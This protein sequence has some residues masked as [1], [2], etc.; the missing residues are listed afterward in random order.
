MRRAAALPLVLLLTACDGRSA[1][2]VAVDGAVSSAAPAVKSGPFDVTERGVGPLG[3]VTAFS[4]ES[5]RVAYPDTTV[6]RVFLHGAGDPQPILR[7]DAPDGTALEVFGETAGTVSS[8]V[9][10]GGPFKG[11]GGETLLQP[12]AETGFKREQCRAGEGRWVN[13]AV[14]RRP[15]NSSVQVVFGVPGW[16]GRDLPDETTLRERA[17]V[18]A[19][20]WSDGGR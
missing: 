18:T 1:A 6:E 5:V 10:L 13:A 16:T 14:C 11:P 20:I 2:P 19:F 7:A 4:S 17:Q 3:A 12:W 9:V 15:E 8:V